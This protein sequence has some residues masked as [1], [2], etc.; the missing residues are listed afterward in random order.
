MWL[1][2]RNMDD[3]VIVLGALV[4]VVLWSMGEFGAKWPSSAS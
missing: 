1:K 3:Q 2:R 4:R